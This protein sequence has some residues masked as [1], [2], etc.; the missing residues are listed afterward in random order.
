MILPRCKRVVI[1]EGASFSTLYPQSF[2]W[3]CLPYVAG[4][5]P[6]VKGAA[7]LRHIC[8]RYMNLG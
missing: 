6:H 8:S 5:E 7:R 1:R 2:L 4:Y 3:L